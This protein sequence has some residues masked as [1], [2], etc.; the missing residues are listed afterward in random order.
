VLNEHAAL[1][2]YAAHQQSAMAAGGILFRAKHGND[3][4][5]Q[6]FFKT[7]QARL[8]G[9]ARRDFARGSWSNADAYVEYMDGSA[10]RQPLA[11]NGA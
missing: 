10:R 3:R 11:R 7:R 5:P 8:K 9:A 4:L 2:E 1:G 6:A